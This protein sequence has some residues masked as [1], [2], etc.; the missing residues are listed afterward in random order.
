MESKKERILMLL[1]NY[2]DGVEDEDIYQSSDVLDDDGHYISSCSYGWI[3]STKFTSEIGIL[4][5]KI[6]SEKIGIRCNVS[7]TYDYDFQ[8]THEDKVSF[9]IYHD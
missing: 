5:S 6:V 3:E 7:I 4:A 1:K 2:D 8:K 9:I